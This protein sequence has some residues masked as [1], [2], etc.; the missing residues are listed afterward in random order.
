MLD[1]GQKGKRREGWISCKLQSYD[2]NEGRNYTLDEFQ[3]PLF[4]IRLL[5]RP[6]NFLG[7]LPQLFEGNRVPPPW[8][9]AVPRHGVST[10]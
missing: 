5:V 7:G 9:G 10:E 2:Q 3:G 6:F 1:G 8:D 4:C